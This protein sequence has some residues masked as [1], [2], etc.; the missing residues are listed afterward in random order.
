AALFSAVW[1]LPP[2]LTT[3]VLPPVGA[4]DGG[5]AGDVPPPLPV[6]V[7][8]AETVIVSMLKPAV[9][10]FSVITCVPAA[11]VTG[12]LTVCHVCQ[13]PVT[14]S[15][16]AA[17]VLLGAPN[18]T[19]IV[20]LAVEAILSCTVYAPAAATLTVYFIHSPPAIQPMS[21]PPSLAVSMSTSLDRNAPPE[22]PGVVSWYATPSPPLSNFAACTTPGSA[23]DVPEYGVEPPV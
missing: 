11:S 20:A 13:P 9:S 12:T 21:Y 19:C 17:E 14:G 16:M 2:A 1:K 15:V 10:K 23:A 4:G 7:L 8:P 18:P 3:I 5:G 6:F 22:L